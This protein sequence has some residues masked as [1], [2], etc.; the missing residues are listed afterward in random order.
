MRQSPEHRLAGKTI[1]VTGA[2]GGIGF[3]AARTLAMMGANVV[4]VGRDPAKAQASV[5]RIQR[6]TGATS[7]NALT[8]DLSS[9]QEVRRLAAEFQAQYPRLDVLLNNAGAVFLSRQTTV[10]GYERTFALNHLAP[11]LLTHLLL[12]RLKA[13]A[14]ARVVTVSSM[15][16]RGQTIDVDDV[17]QTRR[18]YSAW[19]AYGE[20]KLANIMFTYALAR[21]LEGSGVTANTLHPGFVATGF[22]RN[23]GPLWQVAMSLVRPFAISPERGAQTSIY[24]ASSP[25][26]A[27][28]SG[29]YFVNS[30]PAT[31]SQASY[32]VAT[33]ERLWTLSEQMTGITAEAAGAR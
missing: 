19:R 25:D 31:S 10:D 18:G 4:I 21:R 20:S 26:V 16:H 9:M 32:D 11:F 1:L 23:N 33:Q 12:D 30:K 5:A 24:L 28:L 15:A 6:E 27:A 17:N 13:D 2:T 14:P 29:R 3:I 7:V 8:A 22:A